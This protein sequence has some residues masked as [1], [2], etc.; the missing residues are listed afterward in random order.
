MVQVY[1]MLVRAGIRTLEQVPTKL[2]KEVERL[3]NE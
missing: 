2:R 3:L 1:L